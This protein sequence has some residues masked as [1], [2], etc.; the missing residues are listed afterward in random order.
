VIRLRH[1]TNLSAQALAL[2]ML[3]LMVWAVCEGLL[4]PMLEVGL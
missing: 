3:L 1:Y 2:A 4:R